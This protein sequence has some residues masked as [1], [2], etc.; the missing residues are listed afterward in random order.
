M[1]KQKRVHDIYGVLSNAEN[2]RTH[3]CIGFDASPRR[4]TLL[5]EFGTV[6]ESTI[7]TAQ[8]S[9]YTLRECADEGLRFAWN[10][11]L[12]EKATSTFDTVLEGGPSVEAETTFDPGV[13]ASPMLDMAD[14]CF[15]F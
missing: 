9:G 14:L 11:S 4:M 13:S 5:G 7:A 2:S 8:R 1:A 3:Q 15:S 12:E 10:K 6:F